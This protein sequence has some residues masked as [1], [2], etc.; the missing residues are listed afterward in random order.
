MWHWVDPINGI[1]VVRFGK[2][3][4]VSLEHSGRYEFTAPAGSFICTFPRGFEAI[5]AI[6]F[7]EPL[8]DIKL[9]LTGTENNA[10]GIYTPTALTQTKLRGFMTYI[11][12]PGAPD[13]DPSLRVS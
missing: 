13:P 6:S 11:I 3:G 12:N 1:Y 7:K 2:V 9:S 5:T 8:G 4:L 10:T